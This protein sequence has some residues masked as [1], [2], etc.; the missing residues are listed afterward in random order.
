MSCTI[1][2][3]GRVTR[4]L[5]AVVLTGM[6]PPPSSDYG[7][8]SN[9]NT[10]DF[11]KQDP[12]AALYPNLSEQALPVLQTRPSQVVRAMLCDHV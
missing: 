5:V 11:A 3:V 9:F 6:P 2:F 7:T 10:V 1:V 12:K 8:Q 4:D